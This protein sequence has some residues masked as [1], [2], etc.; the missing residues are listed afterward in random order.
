MKLTELEGAVKGKYKASIAAL[1]AK[2]IQLEEQLDIETRSD[3]M[4]DTP[5]DLCFFFCFF[6]CTL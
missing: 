6:F 3:Q 4:T 2:I 1:E 5:Y